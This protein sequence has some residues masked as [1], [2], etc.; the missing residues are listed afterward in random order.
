MLVPSMLLRSY[1]L[2][3]S[4]NVCVARLWA[5]YH[6]FS[7]VPATSAQHRWAGSAGKRRML[8][9][10]HV[11]FMFVVVCIDLRWLQGDCTAAADFNYEFELY[12]GI[13]ASI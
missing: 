8:G 1:M 5:I 6:Y 10:V 2:G 11:L 12:S 4:C 9:S 7:W 13:H 3:N